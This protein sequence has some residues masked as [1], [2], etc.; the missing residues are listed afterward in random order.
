MHARAWGPAAST[1]QR[2]GRDGNLGLSLSIGEVTLED[3][4]FMA[5]RRA[6]AKHHLA[7][8]CSAP[9]TA[10]SVPPALE[11]CTGPNIHDEGRGSAALVRPRHDPGRLALGV[12]R[13]A[14]DHGSARPAAR[15]HPH[16]FDAGGVTEFSCRRGGGEKTTGVLHAPRADAIRCNAAGVHPDL[17][18]APAWHGHGAVANT[19]GKRGDAGEGARHVEPGGFQPSARLG[20]T[21]RRQPPRHHDAG[22]LEVTGRLVEGADSRT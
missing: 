6:Q 1:G 21:S 7:K 20:A 16:T 4:W 8:D 17:A 9:S 3:T 22:N 12:A 19:R 5:G 14:L 18:P 10:S 15:H 13:A 2:E 11:V